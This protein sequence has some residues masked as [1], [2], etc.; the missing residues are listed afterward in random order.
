[1]NVLVNNILYESFDIICM[2]NDK[3]NYQNINFFFFP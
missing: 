2:K 1:M 3:K